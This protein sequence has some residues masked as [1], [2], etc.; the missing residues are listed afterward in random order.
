MSERLKERVAIHSVSVRTRS[1]VVLI[2]S[3]V[4]CC[5]SD[6]DLFVA[7]SSRLGVP[8]PGNDG[9]RIDLPRR[10]PG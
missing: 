1:L 10:V 5:T 4:F 7:S 2:R 6:F 9:L 3:C 8:N